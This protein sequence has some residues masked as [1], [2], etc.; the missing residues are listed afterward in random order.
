MRLR[1]HVAHPQPRRDSVAR[2]Y[3]VPVA[4]HRFMRGSPRLLDPRGLPLVDWLRLRRL[5][6]FNL[7]LSL[8]QHLRH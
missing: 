4:C 8:P 7:S 6:I 1:C 3:L 5:A 2:P